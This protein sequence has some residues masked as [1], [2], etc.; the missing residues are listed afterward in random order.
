MNVCVHVSVWM[1]ERRRKAER[2]STSLQQAVS[3]RNA[4]NGSSR[5]TGVKN[6]VCRKT[7]LM[8]NLSALLNERIGAA[9]GR[10]EGSGTK[11]ED[12]PCQ[13]T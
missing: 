2:S 7:A 10:A 6:A 5:L 3:Y 1:W 13:K 8:F 12:R 11:E 4:L 9:G